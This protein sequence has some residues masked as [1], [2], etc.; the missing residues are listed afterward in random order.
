[1]ASWIVGV[2]TTCSRQ[3]ELRVAPR[4]THRSAAVASAAL[5]LLVYLAGCDPGWRYRAV[6][7]RNVARNFPRAIAPQPQ[8]IDVAASGRLFSLGL[9]IEVEIT[10]RD[11]SPL[12]LHP[13]PLRAF[14]VHGDPLSNSHG[15]DEVQCFA[16]PR[17]PVVP[18][19]DNERCP[20][21]TPVTEL[22]NG[23]SCTLRG[24]FK[25]KPLTRM[26]TPNRALRSVTMRIDGVTR[27]RQSIPLE[28]HLE[29]TF[30]RS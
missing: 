18:R 8:G 26:F 25:V 1:M 10:N 22:A 15:A 17:T 30:D 16:P 27:Q 9:S 23:E 11:A 2:E 4:L 14:D 21:P 12:Q 20:P 6:A 7:D 13:E 24:V 5:G 3:S 28:V 29:W 19:G